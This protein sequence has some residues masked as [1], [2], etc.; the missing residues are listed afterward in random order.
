MIFTQTNTTAAQ[1]QGVKPTVDA[2]CFISFGDIGQKVDIHHA[3][4]SGGVGAPF[5]AHIYFHRP[6]LA[7]EERNDSIDDLPKIIM[8]TRTDENKT[9]YQF[10]V[11]L[12]SDK[13][14]ELCKEKIKEKDTR[15]LS[16]H[17]ISPDKIE[18]WNWPIEGLHVKAI[19]RFNKKVY[20]QETCD[21]AGVGDFYS[22][23]LPV[24]NLNIAEFMN[25]LKKNDIDFKFSFS[26]TNITEAIGQIWTTNT[27]KISQ[28]I[29][30]ALSSEQLNIG[31][32]IF[33]DQY[34]RVTSLVQAKFTQIISATSDKV[35]PLLQKDLAKQILSEPTPKDISKLSVEDAKKVEAYLK[36]IL[37]KMQDTKQESDRQSTTNVSS[38]N[39]GIKINYMGVS[40]D[41]G[42]NDKET[43]EK[44]HGTILTF[45]E[46]KGWYEPHSINTSRCING[47]DETIKSCL[48]SAYLTTGATAGFFLDRTVPNTF[49]VSK[50][51]D[52]IFAGNAKTAFSVPLGTMLP[53]FGDGNEPPAGF[54]WANGKTNWPHESWVPVDLRGI[55]VPDMAKNLIGGCITPDQVGKRWMDGELKSKIKSEGENVD[56]FVNGQMLSWLA[57]YPHPELGSKYN[58]DIQR[59]EPPSIVDTNPKVFTDRF[60]GQITHW[61]MDYKIRLINVTP[62]GKFPGNETII[63]VKGGI[64]EIV[65]T[66]IPDSVTGKLDS[67]K[68]SPPFWQARWIIRIR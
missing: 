44:V 25:A 64:I 51:W 34:E 5:Q 49:T 12:S 3:A 11:H 57:A 19:N 68:S 30:S 48:Q 7:F 50:I 23:V 16:E 41:V 27:S 18:V 24:D 39:Q 58:W 21:I 67:Y 42:K 26:F 4:Q 37:Q 13:F 31:S 45:K 32:P 40:F 62:P 55:P 35:L 59:T 14:K 15:W 9:Y 6:I 17:T 52:S 43:I 53:Y 10:K 1:K 63:P 36:P 47:W 56:T 54:V 61:M 38:T 20:S 28:T 33:Q 46:D 2:I 60:S 29:S 65:N 66:R 22:F 8:E